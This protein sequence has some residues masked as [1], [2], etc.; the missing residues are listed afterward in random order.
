MSDLS[1]EHE[2]RVDQ[3]IAEFQALKVSMRTFWKCIDAP[4]E[5]TAEELL[6]AASAYRIAYETF[7]GSG[8]HASTFLSSLYSAIGNPALWDD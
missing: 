7:F 8:T 3:I 2:E 1:P 6:A 4:T 5:H